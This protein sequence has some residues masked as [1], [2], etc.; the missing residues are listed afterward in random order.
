MTLLSLSFNLGAQYCIQ[1]YTQCGATDRQ[2]IA[3]LIYVEKS[4]K[5]YKLL[6]FPVCIFQDLP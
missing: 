1:S 2:R 3:H 5:H 6:H 4:Y